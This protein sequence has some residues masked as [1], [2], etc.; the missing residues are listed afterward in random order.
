MKTSEKSSDVIAIRETLSK[1]YESNHTFFYVL[2]S[3]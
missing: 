1:E 3:V 2:F